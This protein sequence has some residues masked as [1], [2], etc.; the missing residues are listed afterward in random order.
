MIYW[1]CAVV[2]YWLVLIH[3]FFIEWINTAH[4]Q[5]QTT[6]RATWATAHYFTI[7]K[8]NFTVWHLSA[9]VVKGNSKWK[10]PAGL[11]RHLLIVILHSWDDRI[12]TVSELGCRSS[13]FVVFMSFE[14]VKWEQHG[15]YRE[16]LLHFNRS[17]QTRGWQL[18]PVYSVQWTE[19]GL[20]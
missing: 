8:Q 2:W 5:Q 9:S 14:V 12:I 11:Q 20:K 3:S 4:A 17:I 18:F 1:C 7:R 13:D 6:I 15:R 19:E 10:Q 16:N